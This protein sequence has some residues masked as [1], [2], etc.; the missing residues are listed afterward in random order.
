MTF[1]WFHPSSQR[2]VTPR[3]SGRPHA[4]APLN[5]AA[6][7]LALQRSAG[8]RAVMAGLASKPAPMVLRDPGDGSGPETVTVT[9]NWKRSPPKRYLQTVVDTNPPDWAADVYA[10]PRGAAETKLGSGNG[11]LEVTLVKNT[12]YNLRIVFT[13]MESPSDYYKNGSKKGWKAAAGTVKVTPGYNRWNKRFYEQ[14]WTH[15]GLDPAKTGKITGTTMFGRSIH[16]NE[17]VV[18]KVTATNA[19]FESAKLT[20]AERQEVKESIVSMGG[21]A[22]RTT[23]SGAYSNHSTGCAV[24]INAFGDTWQNEHFK[25]DNAGH[26]SIMSLVQQVVGD[27]QDWKDYD[28]WLERDHDRIL[29]ASKRF[30]ARFPLYLA[31]LLDRALG[32]RWRSD[33]LPIG[34]PADQEPIGIINW[35]LSRLRDLTLESGLLMQ[36]VTP[37]LISKAAKQAKKSGDSDLEQ[38]LLRVKTHWS[39]IRAWVE[40]IVVYKREV[41]GKDWAY[42]SEYERLADKPDIK[43]R[44]QGMVSLHPKLVESLREG[45][46][47]WLVD[48][49]HNDQKDYMHFED[50]DA[51]E[52]LKA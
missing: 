41:N 37:D 3:P 29:A 39:K 5:A 40:G 21:F 1:S 44:L 12:I 47:S 33:Q 13:A 6:R 24:D 11:T 32:R 48:Y 14:S 22:K 25:K 10:K 52:A 28:P 49:R 15:Q 2:R 36:I 8:N 23:S 35:L 42:A 20:D 9:I 18:P 45:G 46:W 7:L 26:A 51:Q 16:V 43:G 30:N 38:R 4:A 31:D 34:G 19:Y 27:D 17:L 50:R